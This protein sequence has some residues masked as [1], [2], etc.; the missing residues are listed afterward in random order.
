[1]E[2]LCRVADSTRHVAGVEKVITEL[3]VLMGCRSIAQ[4]YL[5]TQQGLVRLCCKRKRSESQWVC[6]LYAEA[7]AHG[8]HA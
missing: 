8:R 6:V 7:Q 1:M 5:M 2:V 3:A 4:S